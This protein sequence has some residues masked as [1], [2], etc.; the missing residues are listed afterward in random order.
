MKDIAIAAA[1]EAGS[2]LMD[3]F[4]RLERVDVKDVRELVSNADIAAEDRIIDMIKAKYPDH[5]ILC[6]ES[7]EEISDSEYKWIIDPLDGTHNYIY[8]IISFGTSIALEYK[9]EIVLGVVYMPYNNELYWAE[10]GKSAY[11]NGD[12][13]HVSDR[14]M[15]EAMVI[16]DSSLHIDKEDKSS[17]LSVLID[18]VFGLR[19]TGS[20][21]RNL[22]L[23]SSGCADLIVEYSDKPWDFAAGGLILEEAGG[24]MTTLD[25]D[26]WSPYVQGYL[27][28]NGKFHEEIIQLIKPFR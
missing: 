4:G 10:K 28:S 8:G 9:G 25:G 3:N 24:T 15:E 2:I 12:L 5:G 21:A 23:M 14:P 19:M 6:E 18:E 1:K 22:T 17:F 7:D 27:A 16:F 26:K 11:L 13:I 20:T